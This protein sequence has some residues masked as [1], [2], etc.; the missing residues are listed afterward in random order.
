[1]SLFLMPALYLMAN[2]ETE[3]GEM[4]HRTGDEPGS[5]TPPTTLFLS[6]STMKQLPSNQPPRRQ[7]RQGKAR[8]RIYQEMDKSHVSVAVIPVWPVAAVS[9]QRLGHRSVI[10]RRDPAPGPRSGPLPCSSSVAQ[11]IAA[12]VDLLDTSSDVER[13][14]LVTA[15]DLPPTRIDLDWPWQATGTHQR[16]H[17]TL[18]RALLKRQLG[19]DRPFRVV[20]N[21]DLPP[22][23]PNHCAGSIRI[24]PRPDS[25]RPTGHHVGA[26]NR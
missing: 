1:M 10:E 2:R 14:R 5:G 9:D 12:I 24:S 19:P 21:D 8:V 26:I 7:H 25:T 4:T 17:T 22:P 20:I 23:P 6:G 15:L 16:Y 13:Q 3:A 18:F 11:R